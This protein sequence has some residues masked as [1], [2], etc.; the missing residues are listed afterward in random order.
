MD[1]MS[2]Q[3]LLETLVQHARYKIM[4][5]LRTVEGLQSAVQAA[6]ALHAQDYSLAEWEEA[7]SYITQKSRHFSTS[8]E[9]YDYFL[10]LKK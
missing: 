10:S 7:V 5:N 2:K 4:S 9:A 8:Q 1:K 6:Q 3:G